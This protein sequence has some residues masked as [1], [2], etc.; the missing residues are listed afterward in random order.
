MEL[1]YFAAGAIVGVVVFLFFARASR[2]AAAPPLP[3]DRSDQAPE[4]GI[5]DD[6]LE[7][8]NEGVLL[9]D[10]RLHPIF[11]NGSARQMLGI[12]DAGLPARVPA[13]EVLGLARRALDD[14]S[15]VNQLLTRWFPNRAQLHARAIRLPDGDVL[16]TLRDISQEILAQQVRKEFVAHASHELKSPVAGLQT[17]AEAIREAAQDDPSTVARFAERMVSE[18]TRLGRLVTDLLD[19]SRLEEAGSIPDEVVDLSSVVSRQVES[20]ARDA[21]AKELRLERSI[22]PDV[23]VR[24]DEQQLGLMVRNLLDNAL[25]YTP[26]GGTVSVEINT[27]DSHAFVRV[28]DSGM[29]I[30]LEAQSRVFERFYRVDRA[31]SRDR[32]GTGLGLAI[33]KHVV[34]LHGGT[35]SLASELGEG[36]TFMATLPSLVDRDAQSLAG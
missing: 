27:R 7:R 21:A 3:V 22:A 34:E 24:G 5:A 1:L 4:R 10:D 26:A 31:R 15:D 6:V 18:A 2:P 16:V 23:C 19:L 13:E 28:R 11:M 36:S 17:L 9:L 32:G 29:G 30:P 8:L 35:I 14:E 33:V 12:Q 25:R 20:M